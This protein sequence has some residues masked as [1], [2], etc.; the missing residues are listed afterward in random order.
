MRRLLLLLL[1]VIISLL[2]L[3]VSL[4]TVN[5]AALGERLSRLNVGWIIAAL[6]LQAAQVALQALRWRAIALGCGAKLT[7]RAAVRINFV[8]AFFNQV[9][10]STIGGDAARVILLARAGSGWASAA[11]SVMIDRVAGVVALSVVVIGCLPWTLALLQDPIARVILLLIGAGAIIGAF[12]FIV[13]GVLRLPLLELWAPT[14]HLVEVS[15]TARQLTQSPQQS[16]LIGIASFAIHLLTITSIW[17]I[18]QSVTA[19][20]SFTLLLYMIPPVILISTIPISIAGWGVR[21]SSMIVAFTYAGLAAGDGLIV[22]ILFGLTAFAIGAL[23]GAVWITG[24]IAMSTVRTTSM[25]SS[26]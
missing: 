1:K 6:S 26:D 14:R 21:E 8:A 2:L 17:C 11:Y 20:A 15:R 22:S 12:I 7:Q 18:A 16:T 9:L 10:P 13:I 5:L 4:R 19:S 23:G 3:Y 25:P 24:D